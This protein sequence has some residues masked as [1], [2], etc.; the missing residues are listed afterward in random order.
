VPDGDTDSPVFR[1]HPVAGERILSVAD[2][3][4]PV[5]RL[6]RSA[7]ERWDGR[8]FPDALAGEQIPLGARIIAVCAAA[9]EERRR[10]AGTRFDPALVEVAH[11]LDTV[12][13][14]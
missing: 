1:Q 4:R 6:V 13:S 10:G 5:A 7:C 3:M 11:N 12:V 9:P 14:G 2:S 8:G